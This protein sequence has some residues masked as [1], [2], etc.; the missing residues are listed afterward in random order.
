V[1]ANILDRDESDD[2]D[3][4]AAPKPPKPQKRNK[5]EG[6]LS[7]I[8]HITVGD[9]DD[10]ATIL[11]HP[12]FFDGKSKY[13]ERACEDDPQKSTFEFP[14]E[15]P[16]IFGRVMNW[17]YGKGFLLP[18]DIKKKDNNKENDAEWLSTQGSEGSQTGDDFDKIVSPELSTKR[19][20][21]DTGLDISDDEQETQSAF[22]IKPENN[23]P[24]PLDTLTLSKIY[25]VAEF[26]EMNDLCNEI[27]ELLGARLGHDVKT[28]GQALTYAFCRCEVD[29]PLCKL[30][31]DFT[32]SSAPILDLLQDATFD[33]TLEL[34]RA[35][36]EGLTRVRGADVLSRG[37]W[38]QHFESTLGEYR[39]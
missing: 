31:V 36:V 26:L 28:P 14:D 21:L 2:E 29:S 11:I 16:E 19:I 22:Q 1:L 30:L 13:F 5:A 9:G 17:I 15:E 38:A 7:K 3:A 25:A 4:D 27:I 34:W 35:L 39:V 37:D 8:I 10:V 24:T 23:A 32:A 6:I 18:K 12:S 20:S 33:A